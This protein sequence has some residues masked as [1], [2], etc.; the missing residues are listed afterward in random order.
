MTVLVKR[1]PFLY[2][3]KQRCG[4]L[5][6]RGRKSTFPVRFCSFTC[7]Q[8]RHVVSMLDEDCNT[9]KSS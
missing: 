9:T 6:T 2:T 4:E 5:E 8:T 3:V 1:G 7:S